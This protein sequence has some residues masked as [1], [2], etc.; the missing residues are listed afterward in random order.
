VQRLLAK[1]DSFY[2]EGNKGIALLPTDCRLAILSISHIYQ[3]IKD[4]IIENGYN[5][6]SFRAY[7]STSKKMVLVSQALW[8]MYRWSTPM[9]IHFLLLLF[10]LQVFFKPV[11]SVLSQF[12]KLKK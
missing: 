3:H 7:T 11:V 12:E 5:S 10:I 2:E 6:I 1:A 8:E 4:G 9:H